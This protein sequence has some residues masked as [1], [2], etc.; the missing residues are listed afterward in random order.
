MPKKMATKAPSK[1]PKE[2]KVFPQWCGVCNPRVGPFTMR[3]IKDHL[4]IEHDNLAADGAGPPWN[5][6]PRFKS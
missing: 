4:R 2:P 5:K 3:E 1:E 6:G